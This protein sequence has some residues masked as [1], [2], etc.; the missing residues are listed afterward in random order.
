M[1]QPFYTTPERT[2]ALAIEAELWLGTPWCAN[3]EALGVRG[4]VSCHN[5]PR[6]LYI[7]T[8]ALAPSFPKIQGKPNRHARRSDME[9]FLDARPEFERVPIEGPLKEIVQTGDLLGLRIYHCVDHL[10]VCVGSS[11]I[12]VLMHKHTSLD[13]FRVS[14]WAERVKAIW[15]PIERGE[16]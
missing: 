12:H 14:P 3:S 2:A 11:F 15:R 6:A 9:T 4:G 16:S 7:R 13:L 10:G 8:G 1:I 5:L